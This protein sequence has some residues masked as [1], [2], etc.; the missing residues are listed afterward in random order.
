M[1]QEELLNEQQSQISMFSAVSD[2]KEAG[3]YSQL[4]SLVSELENGSSF[5]DDHSTSILRLQL[6][7]ELA[8]F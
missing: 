7:Q 1:R 8:I 3:N 5:Q 2:I 6:G 4:Q